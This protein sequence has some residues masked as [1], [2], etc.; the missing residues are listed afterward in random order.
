M[1]NNPKMKNNLKMEK[2]E[3]KTHCKLN[4]WINCLIA[5]NC[6]DLQSSN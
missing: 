6:I 1:K 4:K 2:N 3:T 5:I